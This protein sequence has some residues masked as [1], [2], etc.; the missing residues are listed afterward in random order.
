MR[1]FLLVASLLIACG[2]SGQEAAKTSA[3]EISTQQLCDHFVSISGAKGG[4]QVAK[5]DRKKD[6]QECLASL[7]A[8]ES[9]LKGEE[10]ANF[11][12]C[13]LA[14]DSL[15]TFTACAPS[16]FV[17]KKATPPAKE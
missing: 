14:A 10:R 8:M 9:Q 3:S 2:T 12:K 13:G 6:M 11:R 15:E 7:P 1:S 5:G 17:P 4:D 16:L